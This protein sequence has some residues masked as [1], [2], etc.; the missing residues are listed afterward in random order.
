MGVLDEMVRAGADYERDWAAALHFWSD[1]EPDD[2]GADDLQAAA[3]AAYQQAGA[4]SGAV[5]CCYH[6]AMMF[7]SGGEHSLGRGWTTRTER[8]LD[9]VDAPEGGYLALLHIYRHLDAGD[10]P[11]ATEAAEAAEAGHQHG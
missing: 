1:L 9:G 10:L 11:A 2:M 6:L 8:L 5:R 4:V 7:R 3:H